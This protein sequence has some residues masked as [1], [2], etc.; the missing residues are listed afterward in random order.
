MLLTINRTIHFAG[1]R[2]IARFDG[3]PVDKT[4]CGPVMLEKLEMTHI[5][6]YIYFDSDTCL[7]KFGHPCFTRI[8]S[9][10]SMSDY[11]IKKNA[12]CTKLFHG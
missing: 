6:I 4:K 12:T 7:K 5:Y 1:L 2:F 10:L 11:Q 3:F 9:N 8:D